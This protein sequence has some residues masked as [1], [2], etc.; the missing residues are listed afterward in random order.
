MGNSLSSVSS[1]DPSRFGR[2]SDSGLLPSCRSLG[3]PR[4]G[5]F[6]LPAVVFN[7]YECIVELSSTYCKQIRSL[8]RLGDVPLDIVQNSEFIIHPGSGSVARPEQ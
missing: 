5:P 2:A 1:M 6:S 7:Q 8:P 4:N 3:S